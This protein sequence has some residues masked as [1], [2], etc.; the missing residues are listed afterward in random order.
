MSSIK[1]TKKDARTLQVTRGLA[2]L[3]EITRERVDGEDEFIVTW[4]SGR[5]DRHASMQEARDNAL[6]A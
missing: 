4:R 6:K 3:A 1:I 2:I 5:I